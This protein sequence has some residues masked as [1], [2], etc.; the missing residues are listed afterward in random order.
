MSNAVFPTLP[1]LG[2]SVTKQPNW[3]T[4]IQKSVSGRE[5]RAQFYAAPLY[6]IGLT[7]E[8]LRAATAYAELQSLMGFF[9]NRQGSFDS[10]LYTDPT[11]NSVTG[12]S[13]GAGDGSTR[14]F[15]LVRAYG[16]NTEPVMNLN[17]NPAIYINGALKT[18]TTDYTI[19]NGMVTFV[20]APSGGGALTWTGNYYYRCRFMQD[21]ADFEN[22]MYQLW[23]LKKLELWGCLGNKI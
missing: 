10:F 19:S 16:G 20:A 15:Q 12:Q 21:A 4:R 3:S 13:F 18:L 11:D 8:V 17:G 1:G 5:L 2:W 7:Y 23:T 6:K 14:A 22:F 9:N